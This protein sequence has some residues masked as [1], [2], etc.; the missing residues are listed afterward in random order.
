[1]IRSQSG[2]LDDAFSSPIYPRWQQRSGPRPRL[3]SACHQRDRGRV[4][5][6]RSA[7]AGSRSIGVGPLGRVAEVS[8]RT[9]GRTRRSWSRTTG[10]E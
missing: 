6:S 2:Q 9:W 5:R 4:T 8:S 7:M 1:L 10:S 3:R